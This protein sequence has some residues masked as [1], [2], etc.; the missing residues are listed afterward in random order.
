[1]YHLIRKIHTDYYTQLVV[2][3]DGYLYDEYCKRRSTKYSS[4]FWIYV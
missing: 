4:L 2:S 3:K 1:M